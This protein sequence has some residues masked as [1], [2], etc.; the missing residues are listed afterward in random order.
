MHRCLQHTVV[1]QD[2]VILHRQ[3]DAGSPGSSARST[4]S[5]GSCAL[6]GTALFTAASPTALSSPSCL[7]VLRR[8]QGTN[9][10]A[11][12]FQA[13]GWRKGFYLP[14]TSDSGIV[15]LRQWLEQVAG[16]PRPA[17][18]ALLRPSAVSALPCPDLP[19]SARLPPVCVLSLP[20]LP[21]PPSGAPA[22]GGVSWGPNVASGDQ[23]RMQPETQREVLLD[24]YHQHTGGCRLG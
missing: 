11:P 13:S 3:V 12:S 8:L 1:A 2:I 22:G 16:K 10:A 21:V 9:M 19:G 5:M 17:R 15:V 6:R 4:A 18:R 14:T 7:P 24:H 23:G 20:R